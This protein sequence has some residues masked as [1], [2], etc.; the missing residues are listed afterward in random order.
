MIPLLFLPLGPK[1]GGNSKKNEINKNDTIGKDCL[2]SK[3]ADYIYKKV[4]VG[5]LVNKNTMKEEIDTGVELDRMVNN[6]GDIHID[7]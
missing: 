3:Q 7:S 2:T 1:L 6:S 4:E 5:S